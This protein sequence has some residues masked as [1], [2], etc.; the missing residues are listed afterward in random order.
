MGYH[1]KEVVG[2]L[3]VPECCIQCRQLENDY[4]ELHEISFWY[5]LR[6]LWLPNRKRVCKRQD[7]LWRESK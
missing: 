1:A 2:Y 4:D 6:G 3:N 7:H 5:C